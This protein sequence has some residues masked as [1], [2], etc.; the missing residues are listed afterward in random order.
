MLE[1][2]IAKIASTRLVAKKISSRLQKQ[3]DSIVSIALAGSWALGIPSP[4]DIDLVIIFKTVSGKNAFH[5]KIG[6]PPYITRINLHNYSCEQFE[7]WMFRRGNRLHLVKLARLIT[8]TLRNYPLIKKSIIK[9]LGQ[10]LISFLKLQEVT[11]RA[12]QTL[13]TLS[14]KSNYLIHLQ[15]RQ[16]LI[17]NKK[18][19]RCE[20]ILYQPEG[21]YLLLEAYLDGQILNS[22]MH[23]LLINFSS[24]SKIFLRRAIQ[25]YDRERGEQ[26]ISLY[27][28]LFGRS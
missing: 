26:L 15:K 28:H 16:K 2:I 23:S 12:G 1:E 27:N 8:R 17:L 22:E 5:R 13:F 3:D 9:V 20:K 14:D 21:F 11:P 18:M 4:T 25:C 7:K 6:L 24:D 10:H 19:S